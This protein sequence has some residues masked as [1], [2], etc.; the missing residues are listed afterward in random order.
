MIGMIAFCVKM[1]MLSLNHCVTKNA[2]M[3]VMGVM[4][5]IHRNALNVLQI[6]KVLPSVTYVQV[7]NMVMNVKIV[8]FSVKNVLLMIFIVVRNVIVKITD[9]SGTDNANVNLDFLI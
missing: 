6:T 5:K 9:I 4:I 3:H 2:A 8:Q 7:E 1:V